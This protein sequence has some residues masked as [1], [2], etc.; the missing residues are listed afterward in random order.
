MPA[1]TPATAPAAVPAP[2]TIEPVAAPAR[3]APPIWLPALPASEITEFVWLALRLT[4][5]CTM[6]WAMP[7]ACCSAAFKNMSDWYSSA[8][9]MEAS[10]AFTL[11]RVPSHPAVA[12]AS[13]LAFA[14]PFDARAL[15]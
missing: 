3:A 8:E 13:A 1:P 11:V 14:V 10:A 7:A 4:A 9:L 6:D 5:D 12:E 15:E 2:G